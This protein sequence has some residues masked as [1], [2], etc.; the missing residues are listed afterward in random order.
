MLDTTYPYMGVFLNE[1]DYK[2]WM[3]E[4]DADADDYEMYCQS[5]LPIRNHYVLF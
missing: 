5:T 1:E 2:Q 4:S 3:A